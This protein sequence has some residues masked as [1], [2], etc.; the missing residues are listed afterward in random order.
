MS[1]RPQIFSCFGDLLDYPGPKLADQARACEGLLKA[2]FP[3]AA[4]HLAYFWAFAKDASPGQLEEIYTGTFD[5]NPACYIF[6]GYLLFGESFKRGKFLVGL[7]ERYQQRGFSAG[8]E[9]A[10]H[11]AVMFRFLATLKVDD[12][13]ARE[14]LED[15]LLPVVQ[16]MNKN[17]KHDQERPNPYARVLQ[18]VLNVL[19]RTQ[20]SVPVSQA[21]QGAPVSS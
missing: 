20:H 17:F 3:Q 11:L 12:V 14:L 4:E 7:Q 18:A 19:E 9:L 13:L 16:R 5:L 6:A 10:D 8:N 15:C 2:H 21:Q 1:E